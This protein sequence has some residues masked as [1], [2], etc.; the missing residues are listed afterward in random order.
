[1]SPTMTTIAFFGASGGCGLSALKQAL[2]AGHFCVALCRNPAKLMDK[3]PA[4]EHPNL[5]VLPGN[6]HDADA[7]GRCL[8]DPSSDGTRLVDAVLFS[9]GSVFQMSKLTIEDPHVCENG[10]TALLEALR[11]ARA[12]GATGRPNIVAIS[13]TGI[14]KAGRDF[15]VLVAPLY[16]FL[17]RVAHADKRIL[18]EKLV[19][20]GETYAIVRPSLLVDG[21]TK[22]KIRVG[23]EDW[24]QGLEKK[25]VGYSISR[26]DIGRWIFE[27]L[28]Q[29]ERQ[30][31]WNKIVSLT[32]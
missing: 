24:E 22:K 31:Y 12:R 20:A 10:I 17:L 11:E 2:S 25:E 19:S 27:N 7:V 14:S 1:M 8:V 9:I 15:P 21:E 3:F 23:I 6:A 18:E 32:W 16:R 5:T 13:S 4:G 26:E 28:L 30:E 29:G